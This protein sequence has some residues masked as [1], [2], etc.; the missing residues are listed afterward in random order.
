[1]AELPWKS[2]LN[3][4]GIGRRARARKTLIVEQRFVFYSEE[5]GEENVRVRELYSSGAAL[6]AASEDSQ[7]KKLEHRSGAQACDFAY[8]AVTG[9]AIP[10]ETSESL[11]RH[12]RIPGL[13]PAALF[14]C[15]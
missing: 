9:Y 4:C 2:E 8:G 1:V 14:G 6:E 7:G 15:L 3:A 5:C 10:F 12:A 11:T 13:R